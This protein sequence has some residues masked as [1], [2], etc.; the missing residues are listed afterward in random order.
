MKI[1][2]FEICRSFWRTLR[3]K[4]ENYNLYINIEL[5]ESELEELNLKD[6]NLINE[7]LQEV[8]GNE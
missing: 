2:G 5:S 3:G 4:E 1:K 6:L 7:V 8:K